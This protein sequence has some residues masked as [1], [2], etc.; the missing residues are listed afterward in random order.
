M[1]I[2]KF[3]FLFLMNMLLESINIQQ[4]VRMAPRKLNIVESW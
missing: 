4:Y 3:N 1:D 2:I